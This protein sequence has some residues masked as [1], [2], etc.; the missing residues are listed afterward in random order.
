M[1]LTT[2]L[3]TSWPHRMSGGSWPQKTDTFLVQIVTTE[4]IWLEIKFHHHNPLFIH[5]WFWFFV[6]F[7]IQNIVMFYPGTIS[8]SK[9][10][11]IKVKI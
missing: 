3:M 9:K 6:Q 7:F 2:C 1:F 10:I 5:I 11:I 8:N 4:Y